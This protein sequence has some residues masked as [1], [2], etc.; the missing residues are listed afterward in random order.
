MKLPSFL[1]ESSAD[2]A[3]TMQPTEPVKKPATAKLSLLRSTLL[4]ASLAAAACGQDLPKHTK[5]DTGVQSG[6]GQTG[7]GNIDAGTTNDAGFCAKLDLS[8]PNTTNSHNVNF[9]A[10]TI[11][12]TVNL[13]NFDL[14]DGPVNIKLVGN[15][16]VPSQYGGEPT[17]LNNFTLGELNNVY[18]GG[19]ITLIGNWLGTNA[20][21]LESYRVI[22]EDKNGKPITAS[23]PTQVRY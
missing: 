2:S 8:N 13:A 3:N 1:S 7:G 14:C 20:D 23:N 9:I 15:L 16:K 6:G 18:S 21:I 11:Y 5:A 22:I 19:P 10:Q 4:A 17:A 12:V